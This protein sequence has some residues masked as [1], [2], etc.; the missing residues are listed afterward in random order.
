MLTSEFG[1]FAVL[2]RNFACELPSLTAVPA[3]L[4][5]EGGPRAGVPGSFTSGWR[6]LT[7]VTRSFTIG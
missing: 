3:N 4:A 7:E 2:T 5:S 1:P 6:L